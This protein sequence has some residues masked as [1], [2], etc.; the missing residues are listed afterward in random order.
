VKHLGA[1]DLRA[2]RQAPGAARYEAG[3]WSERNSA[4]VF[5]IGWDF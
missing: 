3:I 1:I 2:K 4:I 5:R